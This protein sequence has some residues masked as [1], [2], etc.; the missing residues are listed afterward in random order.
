[1]L[2]KPTWTKWRRLIPSQY[3]PVFPAWILNIALLAS[4]ISA[5]VDSTYSN[6]QLDSSSTTELGKSSAQAAKNAG[7][8]TSHTVSR[9]AL[10]GRDT[11]IARWLST[12]RIA[13]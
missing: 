6:R 13:I 4:D 9:L 2:A 10:S 7:R 12:K 1:M 11:Q 5:I 3:L 8:G